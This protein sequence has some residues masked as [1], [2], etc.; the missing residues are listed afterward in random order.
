MKFVP[1]R[2]AYA[3]SPPLKGADPE[4]RGGCSIEARDPNSSAAIARHR[5]R[6]ATLGVSY[7][8]LVAAL[9]VLSVGL[10]AA[11]QTFHFV[12]TKTRT[13]K[14]DAVAMRVMENEIETLRALPFSQLHDAAAGLRSEAPELDQLKDARTTVQISP[15]PAIPN[16]LKQVEI[17][18]QWTG[19]NGRHRDLSTVTLIGDRGGAP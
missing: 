10:M 5:Y 16:Y 4:G 15:Y 8:E 17:S 2:E 19:D 3:Q 1:R 13:I 7:L 18:V 12:L 9:F 14:E 6:N 11:F